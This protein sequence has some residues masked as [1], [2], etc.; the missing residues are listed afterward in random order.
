[1]VT[2]SLTPGDVPETSTLPQSR[3][4]KKILL[5]KTPVRKAKTQLVVL[6]KPQDGMHLTK[7]P[8]RTEQ[9]NMRTNAFDPTSEMLDHTFL[10]TMVRPRELGWGYKLCVSA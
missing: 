7:V 5:R 2:T 10:G 4:P 6:R 9:A 8:S 3:S 1:M